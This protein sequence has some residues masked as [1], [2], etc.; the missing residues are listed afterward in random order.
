MKQSYEKTLHLYAFYQTV[1][2][3]VLYSMPTF[4]VISLDVSLTAGGKCEQFLED[5]T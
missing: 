4:Q 1:S 2:K 5:V 3:A